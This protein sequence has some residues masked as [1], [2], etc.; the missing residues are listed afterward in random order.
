MMNNQL[1]LQ[2]KTIN[3]YNI[4]IEGSYINTV[5]QSFI[6]LD[7]INYWIKII[8]NTQVV[9]K[10]DCSLTK[11]FYQL[12]M[13]LLNIQQKFVDST[14]LIFH[15]QNKF[16]QIYNKE[17]KND[18]YH[19]Y[20]YFLELLHFENNT[21]QNPNYNIDNYK[22]Q[23]IE[24]MKNDSYMLK[25]YAEYFQ[26]TQNSLISDYFFNTE[27]YVLKCQ[28]CSKIYYYGHTK[29][30]YFNVDKYRIFRDSGYPLRA[31]EKL[32]L[33]DCF[34]CYQGGIKSMCPNCGNFESYNYKKIF[35][36]TRVIIIAFKRE[37][38]IYKGDINFGLTFSISNFVINNTISSMNYGLKS[39]IYRIGNKTKYCV[40]VLINNNWIR[41]YENQIKKI[42]NINELYRFEPEMLIYE[43]INDQT[44]YMNPFYKQSNILNNNNF[45]VPTREQQIMAQMQQ[46]Q[47]MKMMQIIQQNLMLNQFNLNVNK[48]NNN[49][50]LNVNGDL[51]SLGIILK[52]LIIPEDWD[53]S[54][55]NSQQIKPQVNL[56][57][58][59]EKAIN[60][61]FIK[62]QKPREAI[63]KFVFNDIEIESNS[64]DKLED[65]NI[66]ENS[67]IYAYKADN[68]DDL[69]L[70][71]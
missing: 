16:K 10:I 33:D 46:L 12:F 8:N 67:I 22:N 58:T 49:N 70:I 62:L 34:L 36:S 43:L 14:N 44:S 37:N 3:N 55:N 28:T 24:N 68:F 30:F 61:F 51:Q 31:G 57:D 11:E 1:Q 40:D 38:H 19:F 66:N 29:I 56:N 26:Q 7:C 6:H 50:N 48:N 39:I 64:Q 42:D 25:A 2:I 5:L 63:K 27:K 9:N 18:P 13:S 41:F 69:K 21:P 45:F 52:F 59:V 65:L 20:Y 53:H 54:P 15:F 47:M 4:N 23:T 60:N 35:T 71:N 32:T 17:M